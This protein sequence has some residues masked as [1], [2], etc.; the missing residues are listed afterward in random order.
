ML[1][2]FLK[3]S[4]SSLKLAKKATSALFKDAI[5]SSLI[6]RYF[7][8]K[9]PNNSFINPSINT[10]S[11]IIYYDTI[12]QL[13]HKNESSKQE[14]KAIALKFQKIL[15]LEIQK[16]TTQRML[17]GKFADHITNSGGAYEIFPTDLECHHC[18]Q[19]FSLNNI[20]NNNGPLNINLLPTVT[21]L[22]HHRR[23]IQNL[24]SIGQLLNNPFK[25]TPNNRAD[26]FIPLN[27]VVIDHGNH[28]A[29]AALYE[30]NSTIEKYYTY[31]VSQWFQDIYY[32]PKTNTFNHSIC[33]K[34]LFPNPLFHENIGYIYEISRLLYQN[35]I[36]S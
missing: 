3:H 13:I 33:G 18:N 24:Q 4:L 34:P 22:W 6:S 5:F 32:D 35:N 17:Q 20:P 16:E 21:T 9:I 29:N 15:S 31:D 23:L 10:S 27:L 12:Y 25:S 19:K 26:F 14:I 8:S 7:D 1:I 30:S 11:N 2:K 36:I 28:S